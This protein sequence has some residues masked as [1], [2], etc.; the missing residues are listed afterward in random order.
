MWECER[1]REP[2]DYR[3]LWLRFLRKAWIVPLAVLAGIVLVGSAYFY[4]RT[5]AR[6]GRTYQAE[7]MFYLDFAENAQGEEYGYYNYFTWNEVIHTDFFMD[8]VREEMGGELTGEEIASYVTATVDS[9]VRYLYVRCNTHSPELSV[10]L[11]AIMEEIVPQFANLRKELQAIELAKAGDSAKDS[12]KI[13]MGNAFFLGGCLGFGTSVLWLLI[14]LTV[15]TAVYLPA[16]VEKRYHIAC[17]GAPFLPEY[18]PNWEHFLKGASKTA[19][20]FVDEDRPDEEFVVQGGA[21][22]E[23]VTCGNPVEHPEEL[24]GIR[25]CDAVLLV[26]KAGCKNDKAFER[27][28]EQLGRQDVRVTAVVLARADKKL[29][30]AYYRSKR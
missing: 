12:S 3:L 29:L 6:G 10:R 17:L 1:S 23:I 7:S 2:V 26:L 8:Y 9:D 4:S 24:E 21:G 19:M 25:Q 13:R 22:G 16:T 18:A 20:V 15:D 11:A 30:S 5:G 14:A 28:L 27:L